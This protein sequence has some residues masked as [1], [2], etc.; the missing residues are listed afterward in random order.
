MS[1]M[2]IY[3]QLVHGARE[4]FLRTARYRKGHVSKPTVAYKSTFAPTDRAATSKMD[5]IRGLGASVAIIKIALGH[6]HHSN[7]VMDEPKIACRP[8]SSAGTN[9]P[10]A[11]PK[12]RDPFREPCL[13]FHAGLPPVSCE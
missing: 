9:R 11:P 7:V 2:A 6:S 3:Q 10:A 5:A 13:C 4:R 1:E 8:K 12:E